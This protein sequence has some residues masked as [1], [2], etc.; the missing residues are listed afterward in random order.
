MVNNATFSGCLIEARVD[1]RFHMTGHDHHD[2]QNS[3]G[4]SDRPSFRDYRE[5]TDIPKLF[6]QEA[7]QFFKIYK[8]V[9]GLEVQPK[10]WADR[11]EA[12]DQVKSL[13]QCYSRSQATRELQP[14]SS[15]SVA[16]YVNTEDM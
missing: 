16:R 13:V 12:I 15:R 2:D 5:L 1:G 9:E 6:H 4:A 7:Q 10:G 3:G 14:R 11:V 8:Q